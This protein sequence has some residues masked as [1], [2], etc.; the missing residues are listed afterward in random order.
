MNMV[1]FMKSVYDAPLTLVDLII[2]TPEVSHSI[3]KYTTVHQV[4]VVQRV[5]AY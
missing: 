1:W 4:S 3:R 5:L 2:N